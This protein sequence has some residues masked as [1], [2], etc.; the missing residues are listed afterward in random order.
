[1]APL[2]SAVVAGAN[3]KASEYNNLRLD[4]LRSLKT[5][6][7]VAY[8]TTMTFNLALTNFFITEALT[9]NPTFAFSNITTSQPFTIIILQ[10]GTGSRV[11]TWPANIKWQGGVAPVLSG[12]N[13]Y[14]IFS[15]VRIDDTYFLGS[16]SGFSFS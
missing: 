13:N 5:L 11:V 10:D 9:G 4:W 1:M 15:F 3:A 7:S 6:T 16:F 2:S 14:D 8:A 12:A